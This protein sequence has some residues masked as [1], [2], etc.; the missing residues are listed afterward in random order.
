LIVYGDD[1][2]ITGSDV[3]EISM[4]KTFLGTE[5]AIKDLFCTFVVRN[6]QTWW[7]K[8]QG[9]VTR[10]NAE[11]EFR[12]SRMA[13]MSFFGAIVFSMTC[14]S[15]LSCLCV[16]IVIVKI[17]IPKSMLVR[18]RYLLNIYI[19]QTHL[20]FSI[21]DSHPN[22]R[23]H[24]QRGLIHKLSSRATWTYTQIVPHVNQ[25]CSDTMLRSP[26]LKSCL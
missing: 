4:L 18:R 22:T 21:W 8:K 14:V 13:Y 9:M 2:V 15:Q 5:F 12:A 11:A 24:V 10:S 23:P 7:S 26:S 16:Y 25:P 19:E 1:I 3:K 20:I 6:L 17:S